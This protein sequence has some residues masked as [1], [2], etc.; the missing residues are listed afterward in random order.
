LYLMVMLSLDASFYFSK[1]KQ[2][3]YG[4]AGGW[5]DDLAREMRLIAR[6]RLGVEIQ[7]DVIYAG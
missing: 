4:G 7:E 1:F 6:D 3:F 2:W 5:E